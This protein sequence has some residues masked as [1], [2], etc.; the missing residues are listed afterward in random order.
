MTGAETTIVPDDA[1]ASAIRLILSK[2]NEHDV[3]AVFEMVGGTGPIGD[4]AAEAMKD[5]NIDL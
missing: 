2:L 1:S 3:A 4:L 5:R